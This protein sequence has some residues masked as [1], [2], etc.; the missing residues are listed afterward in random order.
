MKTLTH[1]IP[2]LVL[3]DHFF[4]VP[5]NHA[6]PSGE[7]LTVFAREINQPG[8]EA[9]DLPWLVFFQ[10]GP[11]FGSPRP[12]SS[13]G[14]LER[15]LQDY[16]V[17]LLDQRGTGRSSRVSA[18]TLAKLPTPQAAADY[19]LHFRADS[20]VKDA[21]WIRAELAGPDVPWSALGQSYG[22]FCI[23]HYL[24]AAPHGLKEAY[25]TGGLPSLVYSADEVYRATYRRVLQ[26]NQ[27]YFER[28]P[29]DQALAQEIVLH[30]MENDVRLPGGDRLTPPRFQQ[31]GIAFGA[32]GGYEQVHYLM[33]EAFVEGAKGRELSYSFLRQ[34]E[35]LQSFDTNPIYAIFQEA[36]YCQGQAS[37]WAA[38]RLLEEYPQFDIQPGKEVYFTGEM[39]YPWMF[40]DYA[41]L[42][43]LE[44]AAHI[45]AEYEGWPAL[46]D[47]DVLRQNRV[48]CAAAVYYNDMYVE[49]AYSE[50][51]ADAIRGMKVWVTN[52]YEH[53]ALRA[54]GGRVLD[55][56]I[57]LARGL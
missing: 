23:T 21:E 47:L 48:P 32:T 42:R 3:V 51:T 44:E 9:D 54:D 18:Q 6:D 56:L 12:D 7:T 52:E 29:E 30:L 14:W 31:I 5:L 22:G 49:R 46:Y 55:R 2:G 38:Q 40:S 43:P 11:G 24:S 25:I 37:R 8:R 1:H 13:S 20:I 34:V 36:I 26:K 41:A 50:E 33:E 35:N 27:E 17:L 4:Q 10:G 16:R 39:V 45:L 57:K 53:N 19:L 15:A 28:Y